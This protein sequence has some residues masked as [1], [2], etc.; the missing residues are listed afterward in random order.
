MII[1]EIMYNKIG[2]KNRF[3]H[4]F[5]EFWSRKTLDDFIKCF[6]N[7]DTYKYYNR[8]STTSDF[9][10]ENR[11]ANKYRTNSIINQNAAHRHKKP[12][13]IRIHRIA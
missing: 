1:S 3:V 4:N 13:P 6:F 7:I 5:H 11:Y 10:P 8:I 9:L 2:N 12:I